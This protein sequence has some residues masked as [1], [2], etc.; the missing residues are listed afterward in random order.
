MLQ[1]ETHGLSTCEP[2][3]LSIWSASV[4]PHAEVNDLILKEF[5]AAEEFWDRSHLI[6]GRW[7]NIYF[8]SGHAKLT[9]QL[10]NRLALEG[11]R[12]AN[13]RLRLHHDPGNSE[14]NGWWMNKAAPGEKTGVHD[15]S[16]R[17]VLSAVYYVSMPYNGGNI[18]FHPENGQAVELS[19]RDGTV[20]FFPA[21]LRHSV[22]EN[23]SD[24]DRISLAF[25][26]YP[27]AA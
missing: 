6:K 22:K 17:A 4:F 1:I 16:K 25:N 3:E 19:P 20:L 13:R 10:L 9:I 8:P 15:H 5:Y 21:E 27:V 12:I 18:V 26:L 2:G 7:E 24:Q 11:E 23:E 14:G